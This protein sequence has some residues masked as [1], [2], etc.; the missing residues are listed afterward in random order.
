MGNDLSLAGNIALI[1]T[2]V[3]LL[4][5]PMTVGQI[6]KGV[7]TPERWWIAMLLAAL[8]AYFYLFSLRRAGALLVT[9]REKLLA[10][11]E[12]KA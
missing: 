2:M 4:M 7:L 3:V 10:V 5:G 1:G 12:G 11:V 8:A 6:R 9:R